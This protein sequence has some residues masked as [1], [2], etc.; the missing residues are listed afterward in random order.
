MRKNKALVFAVIATLLVSSL[1]LAVQFAM[2]APNMQGVANRPVQRSWIRINGIVDKWGETE[3]RGHIQTHSKLALLQSEDTRKT[4]GASAIWTTNLS[5]SIQSVKAKENFTY[6]FYAARLLNGSVASLSA[7]SSASD[8]VIS[9]IWNLATVKSNVTILT[10]ENNEIIKVL[11][12]QDI[13]VERANGELVVTDNWT[14]FTLTIDGIPSL[15]G[16]VF[17]SVTRAWFNP[18]KMTDDS[19]NSVVTR[20][21]VGEV[22]KCFKAMPGWGSYDTRMDFNNNYKIDIADLSTVAANM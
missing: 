14:K 20:S 16:S 4:V 9:G 11:R 18:F 10:D 13:D 19:T 8:Y 2:A 5:R 6:T 1:A 17:R 12:D 15:T 3:V 21:D 22:V 7:S